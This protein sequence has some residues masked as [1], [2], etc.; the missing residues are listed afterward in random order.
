MDR[1]KDHIDLAFDS[2]TPGQS[3]DGRFYYEPFMSGNINKLPELRF[4]NK[5]F[6]AP[7]WVSS[8]TGGT[9]L[10][11]KINTNIAKACKEFKLG[12]GLGSCRVLLDDDAYL[13]DFNVRHIIGDDQ[14]LYANL[15]IAQVEELIEQRRSSKMMELVDKLNADGLIIHVNPLQ[16]WFQPEGNSI[17]YAP[18]ETIERALELTG[19][20]LIVK[21]VGQ[22]YGFESVKKLMQLPL[23]AI[24]FGAFGGTN[25]S[26]VEMFRGSE[27]MKKTY[28]KLAFVGHTAEEMIDMVNH[29]VNESRGVEVNQVIISGGVRD[30]LE[31]Y[32]LTEKC[33]ISA[34][35]GQASSV[36]RH[37]RESYESLQSYMHSQM[38]GLK[39][40]NAFLRVKEGG[41]F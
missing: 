31:G 30:F 17:R 38:E 29:V 22:G 6:G 21:E 34:I 24:E 10:A 5:N 25:F 28:E 19:L 3:A 11:K 16:E 26:R 36:L 12:M 8:M 27:E 4:L 33:R 39:I 32:Y 20:S 40:A 37:A 23:E 41:R 35:Y 1:K 13:E 15:G 7:L 18:L 9:A 14:P 2:Q